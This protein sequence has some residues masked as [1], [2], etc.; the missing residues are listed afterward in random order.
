V[1]ILHIESF[2]TGQSLTETHASDATQSSSLVAA[3]Q[4]SK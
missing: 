1:H 3:Q 4:I 2:V